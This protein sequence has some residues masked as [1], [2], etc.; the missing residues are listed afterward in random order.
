MDYNMNIDWMWV[1][2]NISLFAYLVFYFFITKWI[3]KFISEHEDFKELV[4]NNYRQPFFN[5]LLRNSAFFIVCIISICISCFLL[6]ALFAILTGGILGINLAILTL[7]I[8]IPYGIY[9]LIKRIYIE[10]N[11]KTEK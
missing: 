1:L 6:T 9:L 2:K 7:F 11:K 3:S 8:S 10:N 4:L 5:N